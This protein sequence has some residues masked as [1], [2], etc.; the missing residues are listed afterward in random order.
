MRGLLTFILE[1]YE[2]GIEESVSGNSVVI[3]EMVVFGR[4]STTRHKT[5]MQPSVSCTRN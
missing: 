5:N 1:D 3:I 2:Y 4:L